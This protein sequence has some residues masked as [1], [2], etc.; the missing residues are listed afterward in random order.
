MLPTSTPASVRALVARCLTNDPRRRLRDAGE[1]RLVLEGPFDDSG[2]DLAVAVARQRSGIAASRKQLRSNR[3]TRPRS[4]TT[5]SSEMEM[6]AASNNPAAH[7]ATSF[8]TNTACS[9]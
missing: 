3:I 2:G 8:G 9:R 6:S 7:A 5:T 4:R 1:A